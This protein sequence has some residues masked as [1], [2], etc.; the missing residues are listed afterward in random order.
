MFFSED[1]V[2]ELSGTGNLNGR[3]PPVSSPD[4][5][6]AL[7]NDCGKKCSATTDENRTKMNHFNNLTNRSDDSWKVNN[8]A[9]PSRVCFR[10]HNGAS[11]SRSDDGDGIMW[12]NVDSPNDV[13]KCPNKVRNGSMDGSGR[14]KCRR[15]RTE[16][17]DSSSGNEGDEEC[18]IY[19]YKGSLHADLPDSFYTLDRLANGVDNHAEEPDRASLNVEP[20]RSATGSSPDNEFLEM[21]FDPGPS[22]ELDMDDLEADARVSPIPELPSEQV[23]ENDLSAENQNVEMAE[24]VNNVSD[25]GDDAEEPQPGPSTSA[26]AIAIVPPWNMAALTLPTSN[27]SHASQRNCCARDSWGHHCSSGDLLSPWDAPELESG[28]TFTLKNAS[29]PKT[30]NE[31][32]MDT[33]KYNLFSDLYHSIMAK[34]LV[35]EKNAALTDVSIPDVDDSVNYLFRF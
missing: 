7:H 5:N 23:V 14:K 30:D 35:M 27:V 34:R 24:Y 13:E 33:R 10:Y 2:S 1:H 15:S 18:C 19:Y 3:S 8:N 22:V 20:S 11:T 31:G 6:S 17:D 26:R 16:D 25:W 28:E 12:N 29:S 4:D 21:D 9:G 32:A